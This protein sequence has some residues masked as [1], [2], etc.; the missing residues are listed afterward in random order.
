[1]ARGISTSETDSMVVLG[2]NV[3]DFRTV[4]KFASLVH[5]NALVVDVRGIASKPTIEPLDG[6]FLGSASGTLD[7]AAV[8]VGD[9]DATCLS[10]ESSTLFEALGVLGG[11]NDKTE[12]NAEALE[13]GGGF[14]RVVFATGRFLE[15]VGRRACGAVVDLSGN[16]E[17]RDTLDELAG[18]GETASVAMGKPLV[19]KDVLRVTR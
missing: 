9:S 11:L 6:G 8:M 7:L 14:E 15:F 2:K 3:E 19:P 18:F 1:M 12:V 4:A 5:D 16:R 13:A 10:I 17:L